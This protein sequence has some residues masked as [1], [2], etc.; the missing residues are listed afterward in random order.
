LGTNHTE[1]VVTPGEAMAVIPTLPTVYDEPF[2]DSSQIPT[3]L[4]SQLAR[5]HVTVCLSGDGGD[6]LFGGY[7][8]YFWGRDIWRRIGWSPAALRRGVAR[9]L[10]GVPTHYWDLAYSLITPLLP[11]SLRYKMAGDKMHKLAGILA[12][13]SPEMMYRDLVSHWKD[14]LAVVPGS[15]ELPTV[16]TDPSHWAGL[17]DFTQQMMYL[18]LTTYL[19]DDILVKIDR[20]GM[21]VALENRVPF[22]DHEVV[23]FAWT[24]PLHMKIRQGRGKWIVRELLKRYLPA[25]LVERPKMGFG[26]PIDSWLRGPLRDWA[27]AYLSERRLRDEGFLDPRPIRDRWQEHLTGRRN[28]AYYLWDILMFET[29][30][31][32][33]R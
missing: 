22:L 13:Q 10:Q 32:A 19:L 4:V 12:V 27:E 8:R 26:I 16:L 5:R 30:L 6:E 23:E 24:L 2:A 21:S 1:L 28:W 31:E 7:N 18:D 14:T 25:E 29:W 3:I 33:Q 17:K 20:A 15:K 9:L 11:L